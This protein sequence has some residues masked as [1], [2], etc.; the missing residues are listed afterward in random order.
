MFC[1]CGIGYERRELRGIRSNGE[2]PDEDDANVSQAGPQKV[3]AAK[4]ADVPLITMA[5]I[6][7]RALPQRSAKKPAATHEIALIPVA[8]NAVSLPRSCAYKKGRVAL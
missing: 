7:I 8:A 4:T 6:A 1:W 3:R 2:A 5:T